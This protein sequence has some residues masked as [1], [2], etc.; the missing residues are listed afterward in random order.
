M[1]P[2]VVLGQRLAEGAG[3]VGHSP[4]ADLIAGDRKLGDGDR[5][6][7]SP[8]GYLD[9]VLRWRFKIAFIVVAPVSRTAGADACRRSG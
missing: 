7:A 9:P 3:P 5:K 4:L 2:P 8:K 1:C 6:T